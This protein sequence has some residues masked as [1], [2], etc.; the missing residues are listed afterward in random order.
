MALEARAATY[1][2]PAV[3]TGPRP[4]GP[5]ARMFE[6]CNTEQAAE[7]KPEKRSL[8]IHGHSTT[9]RLEKAFWSVLEEL[10]REERVSL[11]QLI[12]KVSEHCLQAN[13]KNLASCLRVVCLKYINI[14]A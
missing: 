9:I 10:A 14:C 5:L 7:Y 12:G 13:D 11:V 1:S 4:G 3:S 8:R 2:G 6:Y